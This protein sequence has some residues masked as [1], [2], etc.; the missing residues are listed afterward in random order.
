M[1]EIADGR[2]AAF[3]CAW[4]SLKSAGEIRS[5]VTKK[6]AHA[7]L[8][9]VYWAMAAEATAFAHLARTDMPT[10]IDACAL[11]TQLEIAK[12]VTMQ[13]IADAFGVK[14]DDVEKASE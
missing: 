10:G 6:D 11:I 3:V 1:T 5:R 8:P 2:V 7:P 9:D 13:T 14:L 12:Q 4:S